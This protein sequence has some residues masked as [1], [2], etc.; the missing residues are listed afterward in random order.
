[1]EI[2]FAPEAAAVVWVLLLA[3]LR[4]GRAVALV[5]TL[6][7]KIVGG[8]KFAIIKRVLGTPFENVN[9]FCTLLGLGRTVNVNIARIEFSSG[10]LVGNERN[11]AVFEVFK[12]DVASRRGAESRVD[13]LGLGLLF[14]AANEILGRDELP[15]VA[16]K[17]VLEI[18]AF[19]RV[20]WYVA[21]AVAHVADVVAVDN[22]LSLFDPRVRE[23][24]SHR[25]QGSE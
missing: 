14:G 7:I 21:T 6:V 16:W 17:Q 11:M 12:A 9:H 8:Q 19:S 2:A 18:L 13:G 1:L 3:L 24:R 25:Q 10:L 5:A 4:D 15:V 22:N 20:A 23:R